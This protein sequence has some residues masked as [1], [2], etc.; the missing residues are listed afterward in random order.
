MLSK[1]ALTRFARRAAAAIISALAAAG[2]SGAFTF[3]GPWAIPMMP[4]D[5]EARRP[6]HS[7]RSVV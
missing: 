4:L 2:R 5:D 6:N 7:T 1:D 3:Y